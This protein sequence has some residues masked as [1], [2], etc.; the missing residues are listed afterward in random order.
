M[1]VQEVVDRF[2]DAINVK[3]VYGEPIQQEGVTLIPAAKV[4]GGGGGGSGGEGERQGNGSGF[5]LGADPA[6]A[7]VF[8]G[9]KARWIPAIDV[10]RIILGGQIV[11]AI[12]LITLGGILRARYLSRRPFFFVGKGFGGG[13]RRKARLR[14]AGLA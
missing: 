7:Y 12:A 1:D 2:R 6:G 11:A 5:G 8:Q 4:G 14:A 10:N 3:R 13:F 9:G